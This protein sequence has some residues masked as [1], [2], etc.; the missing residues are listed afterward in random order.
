MVS[1]YQIPKFIFYKSGIKILI[2]GCEILLISHFVE[3]KC[4]QIF[5]FICCLMAY[6]HKRL[7][8]ANNGKASP[9][10]DCNEVIRYSCLRELRSPQQAELPCLVRLLRPTNCWRK[11]QIYVYS[12]ISVISRGNAYIDSHLYHNYFL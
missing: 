5:V 12:Q 6:K 4:T 2:Q 9:Y 3:H 11:R 1:S 10:Q 8:N 7:C